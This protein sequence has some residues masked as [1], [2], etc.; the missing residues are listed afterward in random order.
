MLIKRNYIFVH[1]VWLLDEDR[2]L[3]LI[4]DPLIDS[5]GFDKQCYYI[6]TTA[7]PNNYEIIQPIGGSYSTYTEIRKLADDWLKTSAE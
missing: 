5:E 1:N 6:V 3:W 7:G 4:N 2:D